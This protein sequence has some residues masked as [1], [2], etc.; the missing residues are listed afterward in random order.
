MGRLSR[1]ARALISLAFSIVIILFLYGYL[2]PLG[3]SPDAILG[4][5]YASLF[6]AGQQALASGGS[7][8]GSPGSPYGGLGMLSGGGLGLL[9]PGGVSGIIVY[10]VL[11]RIGSI[12][13]AAT[14]PSMPSPDQMMKRMN[15]PAF[16]GG[17]PMA[18]QPSS[19][20]TLPPDVSRT[21]YLI[22]RSVR[23]GRRKPK[24][25]GKSLSMDKKHVED[26]VSALKTNGYLT[27]NG[28]LTSKAIDVLGS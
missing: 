24:E 19:P 7:P 5:Q 21:Q 15:I 26:E 3:L 9:I 11:T 1:V 18:Y 14:G 27:K 23:D 28:M 17:S 16:M 8:Y 22:L 10:T 12:T 2:T 4:P 25:I 6:G 13:S 20:T